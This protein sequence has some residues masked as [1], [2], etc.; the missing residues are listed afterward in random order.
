MHSFLGGILVGAANGLT[1]GLFMKMKMR[2]RYYAWP[3]ISFIFVL[4]KRRK[5]SMDLQLFR[6]I[7]E[8]S[9]DC[10]LFEL[11][12][13][14]KFYSPEN[15]ELV[16]I[17]RLV[18]NAR[19]R[20]NFIFKYGWCIPNP[21]M[22]AQLAEEIGKRTVLSVGAG[23][24]LV[25][26]LLKKRGISIIATDKRARCAGET[27]DYMEVEELDA[28]S[29]IRKYRTDVLLMIWPPCGSPMAYEA[30][31]EFKGSHFIYIGEDRFGANGDGD[32]H[33]LLHQEWVSACVH[34]PMRR[35]YG[36]HD[37]VTIYTR[38]SPEFRRFKVV[39][40]DILNDIDRIKWTAEVVQRHGYVT[41]ESLK[42]RVKESISIGEIRDIVDLLG[43]VYTQ[44]L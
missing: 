25:E 32:F 8:Q 29:A 24:A 23:S 11:R 22:V 2:W 44:S 35:W 1:G 12:G 10:E 36:I 16:D 9:R 33:E 18:D 6:D 26:S 3:E 5:R 20:L 15:P 13:A 40:L 41:V 4:S 39:I 43:L 21:T 19:Q 28:I 7:Q 14:P 31:R 27:K 17:R 37:S 30:L 42:K 38:S 34:I